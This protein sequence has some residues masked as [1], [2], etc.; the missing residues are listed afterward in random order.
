M[1]LLVFGPRN[2]EVTRGCR[3][4]LDQ[5]VSNVCSSQNIIRTIQSRRIRWARHGDAHKILLGKL[6]RKRPLVSPKR[7]LKDDI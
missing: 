1:K 6:Y 5:E 4:L 2:E 7:E 3:K